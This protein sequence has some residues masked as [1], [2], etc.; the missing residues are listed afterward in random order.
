MHLAKQFRHIADLDI[1]DQPHGV[2]DVSAQLCAGMAC[3]ELVEL[4]ADLL[5]G[6]WLRRKCGII[7][8]LVAAAAASIATSLPSGRGATAAM[9]SSVMPMSAFRTADPRRR[10]RRFAMSNA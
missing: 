3:R 4:G 5:P 8:Y 6:E 1:F 9:R 10:A 2:L 7:R